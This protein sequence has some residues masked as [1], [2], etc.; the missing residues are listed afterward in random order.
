VRNRPAYG[1][2][3]PRWWKSSN[4]GDAVEQL[5]EIAKGAAGQAIDVGDR[6]RLIVH[7]RP[8]ET[9]RQ[10]CYGLQ[11]GRLIIQAESRIRGAKLYDA[12]FGKHTFEVLSSRLQPGCA[13]SA[14]VNGLVALI[15]ASRRASAAPGQP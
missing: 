2:S 9:T 14:I 6:L 13:E 8:N 1:K 11:N 10:Y 3:W 7:A 5:P 4:C 15:D 12:S